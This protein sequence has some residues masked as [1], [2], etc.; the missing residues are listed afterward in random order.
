MKVDQ[1]AHKN[2]R[3]FFSNFYLNKFKWVSKLLFIYE[4]K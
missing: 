2:D 3:F 1:I 4:F